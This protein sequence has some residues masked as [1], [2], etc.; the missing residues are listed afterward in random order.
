MKNELKLK[1]MS[2]EITSE[3]DNEIKGNIEIV[4]R[5]PFCLSNIGETRNGESDYEFQVKHEAGVTTEDIESLIDCYYDG[6]FICCPTKK[7]LQRCLNN[8][9]K[10]VDRSISKMKKGNMD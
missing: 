3:S 4:T 10:T 1:N 9:F 8:F 5:I 6:D 2:V 7:Q